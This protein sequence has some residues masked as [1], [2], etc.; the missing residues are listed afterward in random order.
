MA[1]AP[2]KG[3][4][5]VKGIVKAFSGDLAIDL[6]DLARTRGTIAVD[7]MKLELHSRGDEPRDLDETARAREFLASRPPGSN[8]PRRLAIFSIASI[9]TSEDDVSALPGNNRK[10]MLQATGNLEMLGVSQK[11]QLGLRSNFIYVDE[12]LSR[13]T[14]RSEDPLTIDLATYESSPRDPKTD[15]FV[16]GV[17]GREPSDGR[18]V[19]VTVDFAAKP[20]P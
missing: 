13:V 4:S 12:R 5:E 1:K 6:H 2:P 16:H 14:F 20:P 15:E 19:G 11:A 18:T 7:L 10:V 3:G 17:L 9:E 8:D